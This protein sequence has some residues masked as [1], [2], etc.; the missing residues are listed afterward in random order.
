MIAS[1]LLIAFVMAIASIFATFATDVINQPTDETTERASQLSRC[2]SALVEVDDNSNASELLLRQTSGD[3]PVKN[4]S[5]ITQFESSVGPFQNYTS[6]D[7]R[8]GFTQVDTD[9]PASSDIEVDK[10]TI[11]VVD[12]EG[13]GC[14][15]APEI[16]ARFPLNTP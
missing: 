13:E 5:V 9:I 4:M 3:T 15:S 7:T 12:Q 8:R 10:V 14:S 2:S 11:A 6:I 1:V 16:T